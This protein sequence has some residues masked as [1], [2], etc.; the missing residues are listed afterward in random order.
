MPFYMPWCVY[1]TLQVTEICQAWETELVEHQSCKQE[2]AGSIP[3]LG[4]RLF[5]P[6][7]IFEV[8]CWILGHVVDLSLVFR[9]TSHLIYVRILSKCSEQLTEQMG[10]LLENQGMMNVHCFVF[11]LNYLFTRCYA[12]PDS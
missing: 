3:V 7:G 2:V 6:C 10:L 12:Y 9:L 11:L 5:S 8:K 4:K 1:I